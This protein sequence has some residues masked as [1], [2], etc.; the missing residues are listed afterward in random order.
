MVF[1]VSLGQV[2]PLSASTPLSFPHHSALL[3]S[4]LFPAWN[5]ELQEGEEPSFV[6]VCMLIMEFSVPRMVG[7]SAE[8]TPTRYLLNK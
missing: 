4:R 1:Q 7:A 2:P 5:C 6:H 3:S 8:Q